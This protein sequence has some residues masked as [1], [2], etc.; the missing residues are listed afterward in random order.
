[1]GI[2]GG[3]GGGGGGVCTGIFSGLGILRDCIKSQQPINYKVYN[4]PKS[5]GLPPPYCKQC[6]ERLFQS[7]EEQIITVQRGFILLQ[8]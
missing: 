4:E 7:S 3:G 8:E 5:C 2:P 6:L 1:M